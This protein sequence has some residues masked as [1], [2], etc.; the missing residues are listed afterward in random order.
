[1]SIVKDEVEKT[2][3]IENGSGSSPPHPSYE[4]KLSISEQAT[5]RSTRRFE[6]PCYL[7]WIEYPF[8]T[9]N[10]KTGKFLEEAAGWAMDGAAKGPIN[11][12][13]SFVGSTILRLATMQACPTAPNPGTCTNLV[14]GFRPSSILTNASV[15]TGL[16]TAVTMPLVGALVDH[17]DHRKVMGTVS[18]F[19]IVASL[20]GQLIISEDTWF[21]VLIM[22]IIGGYFLI[23]H[24]TCVMAYL[25]D[26][27]H[28]QIE[29]GHYTSRFQVTQYVAQGAYTILVIGV[30]F[31]I[32][33]PTNLKTAKISLIAALPFGVVFL[34]YAWTFLFRKRPRLRQV[35]PGSNLI[36][37]GF[38]QLWNT[39]VVVFKNYRALKWFMI[40]LLF[41]PEAGAGVVLAIAVTFLTI[42]INMNA[43][44][45]GAV[46]LI[47][48]FSNIPGALL[49]KYMCK[50]FNPLNSFRMS[51]VMFA[52]V[53]GLICITMTGPETKNLIYLYAALIG[54]AFGWMFPSQRTLT[55]AL[56]PKGQE[57]EIMGLVS[58]FG[59]I[60]GWM[61][62][63][64]FSAMN[65]RGVDM[66]WGLS[67]ISFFL[68]ISFFFTLFCGSFDD[69]VKAVQHTSDE[70]VGRPP[71]DEEKK[72]IDGTATLEEG[73]EKVGNGDAD[74]QLAAV[75]L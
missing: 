19:V 57:T 75:H 70:Y 17:T 3:S 55:V 22:E 71:G 33:N 66:R 39:T 69:A 46:T 52:V 64:I 8:R 44:E 7:K 62:P 30:A 54:I 68:M 14:Y 5:A 31:S 61:P 47:M 11:Q 25:P 6:A 29:M 1:M 58:F 42:Y 13:G 16:L 38:K 74:V 56:V 18:A 49:S 23:M 43:N 36:S 48:L 40:A 9:K 41:S 21:I 20:A 12:T 51:E 73:I 45:I 34:T 67:T 35:P 24:I 2:E 50:K 72:Q 59:Q 63:I 32:P 65:E 15:F 4:R 37:T 28:D 27:S 10:I 60:F 53:N 26:L